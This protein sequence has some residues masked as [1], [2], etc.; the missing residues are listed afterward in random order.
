MTV[1]PRVSRVE[2]IGFDGSGTNCGSGVIRKSGLSECKGIC[3]FKF[4]NVDTK[5]EKE[6]AN[7]EKTR[8]KDII[9]IVLNKIFV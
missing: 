4:L 8:V 2:N 7:Y 3:H 5:I 1:Y 9:Q 6:M